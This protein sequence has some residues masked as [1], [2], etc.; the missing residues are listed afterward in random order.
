[1]NYEY[2]GECIELKLFP[3]SGIFDANFSISMECLH[4]LGYDKD[5]MNYNFE[6]KVTI[7]Q[8]IVIKTKFNREKILGKVIVDTRYFP[9]DGKGGIP[10]HCLFKREDNND[11]K[12]QKLFVFNIQPIRDNNTTIDSCLVLDLGNTRSFALL[13]DDIFQK[14][15]STSTALNNIYRLPLHSYSNSTSI[16]PEC[17]AID[18]ML[19][20][21]SPC[22]LTDKDNILLKATPTSFIRIGAEAK[23]I[24]RSL[25]ADQSQGRYSLSSPKRYFWQDDEEFAGWKCATYEFEDKSE[26]LACS[27]SEFLGTRLSVQS[28]RIPRSALLSVMLL[29]FIEQAEKY[30]NSPDFFTASGVPGRRKISR[31]C[32]TYPAAW[33]EH[34]LSLYTEKLQD[35]IDAYARLNS[36]T[37]PVLDVG[38][39]EATAVMLAYIFSEVRK[40]GDIG[41]NWIKSV[42][43]VPQ[44]KSKAHV[45]IAAID[46]GGGTSDLVIA[47]VYDDRGGPG[48]DLNVSRLFRDGANKAGDEFVRRLIKDFILPQIQNEIFTELGKNDNR[49]LKAFKEF[50][51][52]NDIEKNLRSSWLKMLW[53]PIALEIISRLKEN[54]TSVKPE[55]DEISAQISDIFA[56]ELNAF[57][58]AMTEKL[59]LSG[60]AN[61]KDML[62]IKDK[63]VFKFEMNIIAD[64]IA[65]IFAEIADRFGSAIA[66]FDCDIVL[67]AGK[68][69]ELKMVCDIFKKTIKLPDEKCVPLFNYKVGDW[70]NNIA[71]DGIV[72]DAKMI[73][74]LGATLYTMSDVG[75]AMGLPFTI[76]IRP[77]ALKIKD[78][79]WGVVTSG[80]SKFMNADAIFTPE[81]DITNISFSGAPIFIARRG[82][83]SEHISADLSYEIRLKPEFRRTLE[84]NRATITLE[85]I[86]QCVEK[87]DEIRIE[88]KAVEGR[89]YGGQELIKKEHI[90]IRRRIMFEDEFF[91]ESGKIN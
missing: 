91:V 33:A 85:K 89:Y 72:C 66:A 6:H 82:F 13:V 7:G 81:M 3:D 52:G 24:Q 5:E 21:Q 20:L 16:P 71:E 80:N 12:T 46:I 29:E 25:I 60:V 86:R 68:T 38:C 77:G 9:A 79:S 51:S 67:F 65:N 90:E 40:Y 23:R 50:F 76:T 34:E 75:A 61:Y 84:N 44:P 22:K 48:V 8:F 70:C 74:V 78:F 11:L 57:V 49:V 55:A 30:L 10:L 41:E 4:K 32:V 39:D 17:G 42:G 45:R 19:A 73:T 54:E 56:S 2:N 87:C 83:E 36:S 88:I 27:L 31:V 15:S 53:I 43:R 59:E 62:N 1:M 18:S 58:K 64:I 28:A 69:S 14:V 35:G 63:I 37:K 26:R 47:E